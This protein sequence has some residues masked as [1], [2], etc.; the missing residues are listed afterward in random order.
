MVVLNASAS[1][2]RANLAKFMLDQ[3]TDTQWENK[4]VAV[5]L[6]KS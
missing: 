1:I 4:L 3:L 5:D 6:P 2:P